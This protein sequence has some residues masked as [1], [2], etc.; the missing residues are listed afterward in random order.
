MQDLGHTYTKRTTCA[1]LKP[2]STV[3]ECWGL[4]VPKG[5]DQRLVASDSR[6][7]GQLSVPKKSTVG[8]PRARCE[9]ACASPALQDWSWG[10][11]GL[12]SSLV[13]PL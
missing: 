6:S 10:S 2:K 1:Y 12:N 8:A 7:T 13:L 4:C 11:Q 9:R 5:Q 3:H